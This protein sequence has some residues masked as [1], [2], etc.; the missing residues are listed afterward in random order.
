MYSVVV[1][2]LNL[3]YNGYRQDRGMKSEGDGNFDIPIA[4]PIND[5]EGLIVLAHAKHNEYK[6]DFLC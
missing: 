2:L 5:D 6:G 1:P 4:I 3:G